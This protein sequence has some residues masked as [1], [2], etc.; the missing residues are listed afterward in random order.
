MTTIECLKLFALMYAPLILSL[1]L[2]GIWEAI[3]WKIE[4]RKNEGVN[5]E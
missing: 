3:E 1:E 2:C 5:N 4:K